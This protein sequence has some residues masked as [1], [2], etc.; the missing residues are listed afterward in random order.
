MSATGFLTETGQE[1]DPAELAEARNKALAKQGLF[2]SCTPVMAWNYHF[3]DMEAFYAERFAQVDAQNAPVDRGNIPT[4]R[5]KRA[6][7]VTAPEAWKSLGPAKRRRWIRQGAQEHKRF[8]YNFPSRLHHWL[9][10]SC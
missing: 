8:M 4:P 1:V 3:G 10:L 5:L 7:A 6:A 2:A 9:S